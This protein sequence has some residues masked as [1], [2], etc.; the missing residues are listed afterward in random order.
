MYRRVYDRLKFIFEELSKI[1]DEN[2]MREHRV[3]FIYGD[4][5]AT[6]VKVLQQQTKKPVLER[7]AISREDVQAVHTF[8]EKIDDLDTL[9]KI[10][11]E[12]EM[13]KREEDDRRKKDETKR[14]ELASKSSSQPAID[15]EPHG[16]VAR[17]W[18]PGVGGLIVDAL[19]KVYEICQEM[20]ENEEMCCAVYKRLQFVLSEL[21]KISDEQTMRQNRV[22]LMYGNTI[23]N[24]VTFLEKQAKKSLFKRL[25]SNRKVVAAIQE[26]NEDIDELYKLLN[27]AFIQEMAKWRRQWDEERKHQ[28]QMLLVIVS[29]Q[30]T[31]HAEIQNKDSDLVEGLA[32]LKFELDHKAQVNSPA[33]L[34]A[35]KKTFNKVVSTSKAKVPAIPPWFISSDDVDFDAKNFFDCGSFGSVHRGTW[36]K[37]TKVV[38]KCLLMDDDQAKESF[39]RETEVWHRLNSP[40]VVEMYGACHVSTPAFFVCED[41]DHGNFVDYFE[42]D[43]SEIWR[44]FYEAALGLDYLHHEEVVHGDLKCNNILVGAD[45]MAKICDFGFSD[46]RSYSVGLSAMTQT[47]SIRWKA[48]ELL[49]RSGDNPRFLSDVFSFGMCIIEAFSGEP[50]YCLETDDDILEKVFEQEPYPRPDGLQDDEWKLVQKLTHPNWEE[51]MT[52]S[53]AISELKHFAEREK[54]ISN[55]NET[56]RIGE[57]SACSRTG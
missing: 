53:A 28:E 5:I 16:L 41:A 39:L 25:A 31:I 37:G 42:K 34:Q 32:M 6:F 7:L 49:M 14:R 27:V 11:H 47:D 52:L 57:A 20:K 29:N 26:F 40:H 24:F 1:T 9:L 2:A 4:T 12:D 21:S 23:A 48:P 38:I 22:L 54:E 3:L 35:M 46:I 50:P 8:H 43:K 56:D 18:M 13:V 10:V 36:G 17:F 15:S 19:K 44:L 33:T 55:V 30:Q 45:R 51:R